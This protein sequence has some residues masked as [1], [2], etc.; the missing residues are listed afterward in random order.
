MNVPIF[1]FTLNFY[2]TLR[3]NNSTHTRTHKD[4]KRKKDAKIY[5][6]RISDNCSK[7]FAKTEHPFI[8]K[9]LRKLGIEG[10]FLSRMRTAH[11]TP[12]ANILRGKRF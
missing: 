2:D 12:T 3:S 7:A 9:T 10:H 1:H 6:G 11:Q 4:L 5:E 8:I